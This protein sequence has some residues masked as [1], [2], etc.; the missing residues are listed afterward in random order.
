MTLT[1]LL[2]DYYAPLRGISERTQKLYRMTISVY[3]RHLGVEP[4][5]E[6]HL[7]EMPV[8]RFLAARLRD[9][10]PATAKKDSAQLRALWE[11]AAR[12]GFVN[13]FPL[14]RPIHVP[15]RVPSAWTTEEMEALLESARLH[16]GTVSGAP[17]GLYFTALILM[18]YETGERISAVLSLRWDDVRG[19]LVTFRAETRKMQTRDIVRGIS[20]V[21]IEALEK[22]RREGGLVFPWDRCKANL[23][24]H[25]GLI[26]KRA[27]LP[28]DRKSKFHRLRKTCASYAAAAGIDPQRLLD[29]SNPATTRAYL[30]PRIVQTR[31]ACD[32]LPK[33]G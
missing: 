32:V 31:Q 4:T 15:E 2:D 8:A 18:C 1:E 25:M 29:H 17:A 13:Q 21:V 23:W 7:A 26:L 12:R 3:A 5:V 33:V 30:D 16:P 6:G 14:L 20:P 24:R 10:S 11:F 27:K 9:R 28:C 19:G 22:I